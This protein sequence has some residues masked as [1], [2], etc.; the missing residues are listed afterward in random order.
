MK[1]PMSEEPLGWAILIGLFEIIA[2][3]AAVA[4]A[5]WLIF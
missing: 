3:I 2:V 1:H 4:L 5:S